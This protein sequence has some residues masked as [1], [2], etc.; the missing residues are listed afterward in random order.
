MLDLLLFLGKPKQ[1]FHSKTTAGKKI[2]SFL[3]L[4][5]VLIAIKFLIMKFFQKIDVPVRKSAEYYTIELKFMLAVFLM[6]IFEEITFRLYL[7]FN[8]FNIAISL[9]LWNFV[10]PIL[11]TEYSMAT[12]IILNGMV[13]LL[14]FSA[15]VIVLNHVKKIKILF[16]FIWKKYFFIIFYFSAFLFAFAHL[17]KYDTSVLNLLKI[18]HLVIIP[19]FISGLFFGYIRLKYNLFASIFMHSTVNILPFIL[20]FF[21][22]TY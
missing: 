21:L 2:L 3:T 12:R 19:H 13:T 5:I 10:F 18:S 6:P 16:Y 15:V 1:F 11:F 9:S 22:R 7:R 14:T 8:T 17:L 4:L 20:L